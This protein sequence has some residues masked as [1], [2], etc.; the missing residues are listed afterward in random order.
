MLQE[1]GENRILSRANKGG[2]Q[3]EKRRKAYASDGQ[4][5]PLLVVFVKRDSGFKRNTICNA[6]KMIQP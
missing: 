2:K 6:A 3:K 1:K 4:L 5:Y